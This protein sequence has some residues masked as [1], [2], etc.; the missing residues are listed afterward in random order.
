LSR[1]TYSADWG[2]EVGEQQRGDVRE[3]LGAA[4]ELLDPMPLLGVLEVRSIDRRRRDGHDVFQVVARPRF[5]L[6]ES[7]GTADEEEL[8]VDAERGVVLELRGLIRGSQAR[9]LE[10]RDARF[11]VEPEPDAF[12]FAVPA[13]EEVSGLGLRDAARLASFPLWA[14]PRPV[15]QI[16]YRG[17]RPDRGRP[18]SVT[19]EY[20]DVLLVETSAADGAAFTSFEPPVDVTRGGRSYTLFPGR[21]YFGLEG[22]AIELAAA[23]ADGDQL[24]DLAEALV[25]VD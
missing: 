6:P 18:E 4:A 19:L 16:T 3:E 9:T 1:S 12:R 7:L 24:V 2:A 11:D 21:A 14:L 22:T 5:P 17:A 8:V 10:L 20:T 25:R 15:Q 23:D 13:E